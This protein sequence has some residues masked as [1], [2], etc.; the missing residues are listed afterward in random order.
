MV[1]AERNRLKIEKQ[2]TR[3]IDQTF[4]AWAPCGTVGLGSSTAP[5]THVAGNALGYVVKRPALELFDHWGAHQKLVTVLRR[6]S[7]GSG[8][9]LFSTERRGSWV[10]VEYS[11]AIGIDAWARARDLEALPPGEIMDNP[12]TTT[13]H[14]R[15]A[16]RLARSGR[17]IRSTDEVP[18]RLEP[19]AD[20]PVVGAIEPDT[21][22]IVVHE[23]AAVWV[24]V[25]PKSMNVAP[26]G[27]GNFWV[28]R[29]E[30][31]GPPRSEPRRARR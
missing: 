13:L 23:A 31:E 6:S 24:S 19:R 20:A 28:L 8:I 17:Q 25:L 12:P 5:E 11:G 10:R 27:D 1:G 29:A 18:I 30:L 16:L 26:P 9:L 22:T 3:P 4:A 14:S 7:V 2:L 15:R 21:D